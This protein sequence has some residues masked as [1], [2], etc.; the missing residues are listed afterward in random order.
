MVFTNSFVR[1][2]FV[3]V[4]LSNRLLKRRILTQNGKLFMIHWGWYKVEWTQIFWNGKLV[5]MR[6]SYFQLSDSSTGS[7]GHCRPIQVTWRAESCVLL[8]FSQ[9][10]WIMQLR[11]HVELF[12]IFLPLVFEKAPPIAFFFNAQIQQLNITHWTSHLYSVLWFS[13]YHHIEHFI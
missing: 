6:M 9:L 4:T 5:V 11:A 3:I 12:A 1:S 13:W 8:C 7:I 2:I 10:C